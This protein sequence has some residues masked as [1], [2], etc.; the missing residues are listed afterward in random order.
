MKQSETIFL[1]VVEFVETL[2]TGTFTA[3]GDRLG[4]TGSAVG[5]SVT[6]LEQKLGTK[7]TAWSRE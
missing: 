6:R 1:G 2:R 7:L 5:K 3:A 4:L